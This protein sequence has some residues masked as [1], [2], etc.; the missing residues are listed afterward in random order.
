MTCPGHIASTRGEGGAASL[1]VGP[2]AGG[3][4]EQGGAGRSSATEA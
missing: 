2:D 3:L 1:P 4:A